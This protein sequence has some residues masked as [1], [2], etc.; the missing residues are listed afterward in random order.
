MTII[1]DK[2]FIICVSTILIF[3]YAWSSSVFE[4]ENE[5]LKGIVFDVHKSDKGFVFTLESSE[6]NYQKCF[7]HEEPEELMAYSIIGNFSENRSM[8]FVE[9][10]TLLEYK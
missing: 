10:M 6:G 4:D 7:F 1:K 9:K 5:D 3:A 8:L 2:Y